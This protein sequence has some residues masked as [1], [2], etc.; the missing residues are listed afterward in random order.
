ME[1][2]LPGLVQGLTL[3][4]VTAIGGGLLGL[5]RK[6]QKDFEAL[7]DSQRQQIKAQIVGTYQHAVQVGSITPL[8]LDT[9]C[10]L[11]E[12]YKTL[13]GNTYVAALVDRMRNEMPISGESIPGGTTNE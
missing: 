1:D 9:A 11:F 5:Y 3:A 2:V 6:L 7:K 12:S 4:I 8:E 10:R 13:G